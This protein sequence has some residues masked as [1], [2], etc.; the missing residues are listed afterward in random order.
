MVKSDK[1][2]VTDAACAERIGLQTQDFKD[3]LP[4]LERSGF[5]FRDPLFKD[6]HYWPAVRAFLDKRAG[7]ASSFV[8]RKRP[9]EPVIKDGKVW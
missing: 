1:L 9:V 6:R 2:Y 8:Q 7:L 5:P 3:V 4:T